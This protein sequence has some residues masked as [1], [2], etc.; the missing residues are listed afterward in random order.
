MSSI[1]RLTNYLY[2][3]LYSRYIMHK[4][5][6]KILQKPDWPLI[7]FW[8]L[9]SLY[10]TCSHS[11]SFVLPLPVIR[12]QSLSFVSLVFIC[13][14]SLS[15]VATRCAIRCHSFYH[16]LS[17]VV[18][19]CTTRCHSLS[20]DISLVYPFT[21]DQLPTLKIFLICS[22]FFYQIQL[23]CSCKACLYKRISM[24][25]ATVFQWPN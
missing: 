16:S 6:N 7:S 22:Y 17:F 21:N 1:S 10:F 13:C 12:C 3:W 23:L 18:T 9:K 11:F 2:C 19:H 20:I 8:N 25:V 4:K 14:H 5:L 24:A 15:P